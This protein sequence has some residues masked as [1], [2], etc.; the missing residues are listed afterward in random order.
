MLAGE[1]HVWCLRVFFLRVRLLAVGKLLSGVV[2]LRLLL[3]RLN[4]RRRRVRLAPISPEA[5]AG[6][7]ASQAPPSERSFLWIAAVNRGAFAAGILAI[8]C[9]IGGFFAGRLSAPTLEPAQTS[10]VASIALASPR[11]T[12]D[13]TTS[14]DAPSAMSNSPIGLKSPAISSPS[15]PVNAAKPIV[16]SHPPFGVTNA[17][18]VESEVDVIKDIFFHPP[19]RKQGEYSPGEGAAQTKDRAPKLLSAR[20]AHSDARERARDYSDLRRQMLGH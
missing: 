19:L 11:A 18:S 7:V 17:G 8:S 3:R 10:Q 1:H 6:L 9:A 16:V 13:L 14:V 20:R 5:L 4:I 15:A 2:A 12:S